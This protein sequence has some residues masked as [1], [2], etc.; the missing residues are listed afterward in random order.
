MGNTKVIK[1]T[2]KNFI[3]SCLIGRGI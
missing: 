2:I 1:E 3:I